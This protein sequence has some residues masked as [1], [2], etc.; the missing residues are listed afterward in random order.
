MT[1]E[2]ERCYRTMSSAIEQS[3]FVCLMG[4]SGIGKTEI[5]KDFSKAVAKPYCS[6]RCCENIGY[7]TISTF[8][9]VKGERPG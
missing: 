5:C 7:K 6:F 8:L 2:T 9:K 3:L 4:P 1:P